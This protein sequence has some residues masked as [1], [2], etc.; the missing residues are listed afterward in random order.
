MGIFTEIRWVS[1]HLLFKAKNILSHERI[2]L[3]NFLEKDF[4][5]S[6]I[7]EKQI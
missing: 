3:V 4:S 7:A 6:D 1:G 2:S 5:I